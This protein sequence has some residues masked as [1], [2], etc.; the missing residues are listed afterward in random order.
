MNSDPAYRPPWWLKN[1]LLMTL[2]ID[3]WYGMTWRRWGERVPWLGRWPQIP[4]QEYIFTGADEVPLWGLWSR[5]PLAKGTIILNTG[6]SGKVENAWYAHLFARKAHAQGWA[7]LLYD[8]RGHGR[9]AELS[10]TPSAY[11]WREGEDQLHLAEQLVALGCPTPVVLVGFSFGG[12]LALWGLKAAQE[13][14]CPLV[15]RAATISCHLE[16]SRSLNYLRSTQLGRLIERKFAN[17]LRKE[18]QK[19]LT[20]F[21][22]SLP[23][24]IIHQIHSLDSFDRE[25]S[26]DYYG[27]SSV[28]D[29]Y[30][31]TSAL[32][33]LEELQRPYLIIYAQNDPMYDPCVILQMKQRIDSNPHG[34]LLLTEFGGHMAH[35]GLATEE[36]DQ[37]WG[38]NRLLAFC[39]QS[40]ATISRIS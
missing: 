38:I 24:D 21:P 9:T 34:H 20:L 40:I 23:P 16:S 19:R 33:L 36:E 26:I 1:G 13:Q 6:L 28:A 27:F 15:Q 14:H 29:Y 7:V 3:T 18:V 11:G 12:Q 30:R 5:P 32:Y 31:K 25:M 39:Q 8:W 22:N 10:A 37:F 2:V 35:I 4:W 17:N